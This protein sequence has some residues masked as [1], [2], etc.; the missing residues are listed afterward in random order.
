MYVTSIEKTKPYTTPIGAPVRWLLSEEDGAPQFE[1]RFFELAPG[2]K[3][4]GN[5]HDFEHEA[6]IVSGTGLMEGEER[7]F[8]AETGGCPFLYFRVRFIM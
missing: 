4:R 8:S 5:P 6:F 7:D 2:M 1:M 3:T